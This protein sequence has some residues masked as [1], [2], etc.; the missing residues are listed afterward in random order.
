MLITKK[1]GVNKVKQ[2]FILTWNILM[3][4][5]KLSLIDRQR[6]EFIVLSHEFCLARNKKAKRVTRGIKSSV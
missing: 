3:V 1:K 6:D 2:I 4:R 5:L